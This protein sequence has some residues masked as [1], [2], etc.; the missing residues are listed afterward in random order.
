[1]VQSFVVKVNGNVAAVT[2]GFYYANLFSVEQT[3][4]GD[5][6]PREGDSIVVPMGQT[7]IID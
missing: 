2:S 7:L 3:W 4:G 1:M 6:P 5:I